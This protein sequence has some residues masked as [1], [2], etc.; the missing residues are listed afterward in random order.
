MVARGASPPTPAAAAPA[1]TVFDLARHRL[2]T[3]VDAIAS[4][5]PDFHVS[6]MV[7]Y[8]PGRLQVVAASPHDSAQ[9]AV[10][11]AD[12]YPELQYILKRRQPLLVED[13]SRHA[14]TEPL[15]DLLQ[16]VGVRSLA[17]APLPLPGSLGLIRLVSSGPAIDDEQLRTLVAAANDCRDFFGEYDRPSPFDEPGG[18]LALGAFADGILEL[19]LDGTVTA[20]IGRVGATLGIPPDALRGQF[21]AELLPAMAPMLSAGS[22]LEGSLRPGQTVREDRATLATVD[23]TFPVTATLHIRSDRPFRR[24]LI[25][26]ARTAI[27][28]VQQ[29]IQELPLPAVVVEGSDGRVSH[30]NPRFEELTGIRSAD[31]VGGDLAAL[32]PDEGD[33]ARVRHADGRWIPV[34]RF[35]PFDAGGEGAARVAIL[36]DLRA[37]QDLLRRQANLRTTVEKKLDELEAL[38]D[39]FD[40]MELVQTEF[41]SS[42]AHELKTPLTVIQ[43]YVESLMTDLSEGLSEEQMSFLSI[44]HESVLRLRRLVVDLVDLAALSSGRMAMAIDRVEL[45]ALIRTALAEMHPTASSAG[46]Q[47]LDATAATIPPVRAD[48][49]RTRQV[50]R[51]LVDNA[52]R[53]TPE[54]G[55][56]TLAVSVEEDSVHLQVVDT[57][58]GIPEDQLV[59]VFDEFVQGPRPV[60]GRGKGSGLGL[61]ICRRITS[62]M[63]GRIRAESAVGSGTTMVVTLP[64][65]P[66]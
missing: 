18:R 7:P 4:Q 61:S 65:W 38:H 20:V 34:R 36:L 46:I 22:L 24:W 25:L 11:S 54:G 35:G 47:L 27:A 49:E 30:A 43:S 53:F 57:G 6:I 55:T 26:T 28:T 21:A 23:G 17:G 37:Q 59:S 60:A 15:R 19:G 9:D 16:Q 62:A 48:A 39:R 56:V 8:R 66:G 3:V 33:D 44:T 1:G 29:F 42:S 2:G 52:I 5:N 50:V 64:R 45:P 12:R 31:L 58:V 10:I 63:G 14:A 13:V 40:Q 51:N 32:I 41:L